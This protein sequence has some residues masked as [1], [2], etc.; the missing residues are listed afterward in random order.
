MKVLNEALL[1]AKRQE[2]VTIAETK[3][4]ETISVEVAMRVI[5]GLLNDEPMTQVL[6]SE[7]IQSIIERNSD[8]VSEHPTLPTA[9]KTQ[10]APKP[11]L[12][13]SSEK[14]PYVPVKETI[15]SVLT[16][17]MNAKDI[18]EAAKS[19]KITLNEGSVNATLSRLAKSGEVTKDDKG[20]YS[21]APKKAASASKGP[22]KKKAA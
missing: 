7:E 17:K 21:K 1:K 19:K 10:A 2:L 16:K 18:V 13:A 14:V 11:Q 22:E 4:D 3:A 12:V 5:D 15:F 8:K 6:S 20:M 9:P